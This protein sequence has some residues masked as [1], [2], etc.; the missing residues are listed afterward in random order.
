MYACCYAKFSNRSVLV[1]A[2]SHHTLVN[3]K[4]SE[5]DPERLPTDTKRRAN[6][7]RQ[8]MCKNASRKHMQRSKTHE[9][10]SDRPSATQA[11]HPLPV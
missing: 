1:N 2:M 7:N 9:T 5:N 10:L 11:L 3:A 6:E 8:S 4:I